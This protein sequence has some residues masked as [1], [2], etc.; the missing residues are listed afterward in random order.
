MC[1]ILGYIR[2]I[3]IK[4]GINIIYDTHLFVK[5]RGEQFQVVHENES[6]LG[7]KRCTLVSCRFHKDSS[8]KKN[9][10]PLKGKNIRSG[11]IFIFILCQ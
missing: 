3:H 5:D 11:N 1:H 8:F 10:F 9:G 6:F 7:A 2:F 4:H